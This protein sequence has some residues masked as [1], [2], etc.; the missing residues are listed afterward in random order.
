MFKITIVRVKTFGQALAYR[1]IF[2]EKFGFLVNANYFIESQAYLM[3]KEGKPIGGYL[4]APM[5]ISRVFNQIPFSEDG[6]RAMSK[7]KRNIDNLAE[8]N[9]YF[10]DEKRHGW[11]LVTHWL[12]TILSHKAKY[13]IYSYDIKNKKLKEYYCHGKP[14]LL[15]SGLI[16]NHSYDE[17]FHYE[18]IELLSKLGFCRLYFRRLLRKN[19]K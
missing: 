1:K 4:I 16:R 9:G 7:I 14:T 19:K 18:R 8:L 6:I 13:F 17:S 15:Y 2:H 12:I 11:I 5:R 3:M 10:I